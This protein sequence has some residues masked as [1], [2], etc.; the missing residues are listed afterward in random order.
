MSH[1]Q[2]RWL[3]LPPIVLC[4]LDGV[5]TLTGQPASY[6]EGDYRQANELNPLMASILRWHPAAFLAGATL[7]TS[8]FSAAIGLLPRRGALAVA[9]GF[10]LGHALGAAAWFARHGGLGWFA[11]SAVLWG[12]ERFT[13]W[14]WRKQEPCTQ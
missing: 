13:R 11:A 5:L 10:S 14:A 6:W 2:R 3:A 12:A 7:W 1:L 9:F 4:L 8:A